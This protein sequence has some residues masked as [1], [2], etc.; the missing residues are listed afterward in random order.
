M[1]ALQAGDY[2]V[3]VSDIGRGDLPETGWDTLDEVRSKQPEIPFVL[4][5]INADESLRERATARGA[6]AVE[7]L[8]DKLVG[9]VLEL[10]PQACVLTSLGPPAMY[11]ESFPQVFPSAAYITV[12]CAK[13]RW[14][15][16]D[17]QDVN[18]EGVNAY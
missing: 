18:G 10:P 1:A 11:R 9:T 14:F 13:D 6:S 4:D 7:E 17:G 12:W 2:D 5:T 3:V 16:A 8:P 15:V